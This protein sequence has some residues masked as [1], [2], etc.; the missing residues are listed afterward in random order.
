MKVAIV[1]LNYNGQKYL[2]QFL[3]SVIEH[4]SNATIYIADNGS[5]D[6][7]LSFIEQQYPQIKL[8]QNKTNG[9]LSKGY[10]DALKLVDEDIYVLLNSAIEVTPKWIEVCLKMM[11]ENPE[12]AALQPKILS[13]SK[14]SSFD[15]TG[16]AGGFLDMEY[17]PFCQGRIFDTIEEDKGQYNESRE[18]FWATATCLFIRRDAY[19]VCSGFDEAFYSQM[20]D[21]DLC[22]R[23]KNRGY[24]I[25]YCANAHVYHI[26]EE[27]TNESDSQKTYLNFRNSLYMMAKNYSGTLFL[28]MFKRLSLDGLIAIGFLFKLKFGNFWAVF[29]S[30]MSFY[31]HLSTL[32]TQRKQLKKERSNTHLTGIYQGNIVFKRFLSGVKTFSSLESKKFQ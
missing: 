22:W 3:P 19:H 18:V 25:Y 26:G 31:G 5:T 12:I 16:A 23:L 17:Y 4:S 6:N 1:I 20:A 27:A 32:L 11:E 28:K 30:H 21:I 10:N 7:S 9:G 8:I 2:E 14:K 13:Y 24:K 15:Y 29:K